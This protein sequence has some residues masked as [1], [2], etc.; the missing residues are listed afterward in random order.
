MKN[1]TMYNQNGSNTAVMSKSEDI[2]GVRI[3]KIPSIPVKYDRIVNRRS[4]RGAQKA[5]QYASVT[6]NMPKRRA[7]KRGVVKIKR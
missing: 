5:S 4:H 3:R 6:G 1:P 7:H 2:T